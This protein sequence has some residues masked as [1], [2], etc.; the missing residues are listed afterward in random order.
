MT[1][2]ITPNHNIVGT[3]EKPQSTDKFSENTLEKII[4][5]SIKK[6]LYH[7]KEIFSMV[8]FSMGALKITEKFSNA[9]FIH[10]L[11]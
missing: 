5:T 2:L 6:K 7:I 4:D 1:I 11:R 3:R 9:C 10:R 8:H